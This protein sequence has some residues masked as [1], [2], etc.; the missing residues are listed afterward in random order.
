M[1]DCL[2]FTTADI[3]QDGVTELV[4]RTRW[5]EK[6]YTIYDMADSGLMESWQDTVPEDIQEALALTL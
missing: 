5:E 6:P 1:E 4:V 2:S 3:D